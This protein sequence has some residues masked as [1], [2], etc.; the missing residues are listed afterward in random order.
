MK[1]FYV[2]C[3]KVFILSF[4]CF[5]SCKQAKEIVPSADFTPYISAYTGGVITEG[6]T[7]VVELTQEQSWSVT[8]KEVEDKLFSFSPSVKGTAHWL[9]NNTIEFVPQEGEMKPGT[10]YNATFALGKVLKTDEK[11]SK[12]DFSFRVQE[13]TLKIKTNPVEVNEDKTITVRGEL[14]FSK[15]SK[16]EDVE[17]TLTASLGDEKMNVEIEGEDNAR[18]YKFS[19]TGVERVDENREL[20]IKVDGKNV[21]VNYKETLSINIPANDKFKL[22]DYEIV[23]SPEYGLRLTFSD[24]VSESQDLNGLITLKNVASYTIKVNANQVMLFFTPTSK[25]QKLEVIIDQGLKNTDGELFGEIKELTISLESLKPQ[26]EILSS[27]MI[28]PNTDKIYLP[29]RAVSLHAIDLKI[30]RVFENNILMFLQNNALSVNS[31]QQLRRAGRLV[32]KKTLK[33]EKDDTKTGH[34]WENY[35]IDLT[36]LIK[37]QPGD[38][39]RIELSFKESYASYECEN[40]AMRKASLKG[41][42]S[43]NELSDASQANDLEDEYW[44]TPDSYYSVGYDIHRDWSTYEWKEAENPCHPTYYMNVKR[45]AMANILVSNLGMIAKKNTNNKLWVAVSNIIDTKPVSSAKVTAYNYQLQP[46]VSG[47]TD[48]DG[49]AVLSPKNKPFILVAESGKEKAYLRMIERET[50]MLSRFDIGGVE[51]KKGLKGY[52]YGE[53]GVWR[54]GDTLHLAFMLEDREGKIPSNHPISLEL[55][56]PQGQFYKKVISTDGLNGLYVFNI[57]IKADAPTGLWNAYVKVGGAT[58]HKGLRI[59][60]IKPNRLKINLDLPEVID[61]SKATALIG[62]HSKWLTGATARNLSAKMEL[63]LNKTT[64]RFKGYGKYIFNSPATKFSSST[65]QI[66]DGTLDG[67]GDANFSMKIPPAKNAPGMLNANITCRVFEPGGDA[68]IF[69]QSVPFSPYSSYVGINF[70]KEK[71]EHYK[72]TDEDHTFDVV[73]LNSEGQPISRSDIEYKIYRIGWSWWWEFKDE[74][75]ESYVN[76][77]SYKPLYSGKINTENGKGKLKFRVDYPDWGRFLVLLKDTKSGHTTGG[78]LLVDWPS[79]RGR[80]NK[81][82]PDGVK[83]LTFALDKTSYEAGEEAV[84][85]IPATATDGRALIALENGTE[86]VMR[87][88]VE[89]TAGNETKYT[90]KVTEKMSPNIYV[91]IS[92]LQPHAATNDLPIRM[93]GIMPVFVSNKSSVLEPEIKVSDVLRPEVEFDISVKEKDGKPMTY[94]LAIVDEGLLDLTNFK[95]PDPWNVFYAR[96]ALGI[97]TWDMFDNVMGAYAGKYGE[98]FAVGGDA[99]I[100]PSSAKANRFKPVVLYEGPISLSAGEEK[101]HT[102]RL[103]PYIGSVRVMLVAGHDG[104]YG[105]T[106]KNVTVRS[107]LMLLSS[108]PRVLSTNEEINLPVNVFAMEDGVKKVSVKVETTGKLKSTDRK[109]Q[110]LRFSAPGDKIVYF[111]MRTST[112]KGI[113]KVTITASA[114][115]HTSSETIEIDVRNPNPPNITIESK[116]LEKGGNVE[117]DYSINPQN[118]EDWIKVEMSRIPTVDISRRFDYLYN[119]NHYCT[120]QLTSR[121]FPLLFI[122]DFKELDE[123]EKEQSKMNITEAINDLYSRQLTNGGFSYWGGQSYVNDWVCSYAGSFL[124]VA[125]ERGYKV[126]NSVVNKWIN[127]Q[128]TA[129]RNWRQKKGANKRYSYSQSDFLQAY[130]LYSLALAGVPEMGAMNRLK[131]IKDLSLQARWRLAAAY[132]LGGKQDAAGEIVFNAPTQIAPYSSNN[133]TYGDFSRDEAMILETLVL[134]NRDEEAFK[135]ARKVSKNL[136]SE[137]SFNTQTTAYA[138]IAMGQLAS[139][140]SGAFDLKWFLNGEKQ[141]RVDTR[142]TI[143]Q[144]QLPVTPSSGKVKIQNGDKGI[145]YVSLASKTSPIVDT[146][147]AIAENIKLNVLYTDMKGTPLNVSRLGQGTDFYAIIKV[148]NISIGNYYSDVALTHIIPSGWEVYNERMVAASTPESAKTAISNAFTYQDVRDDRILTYFDLPPGVSKEI[149]VRLQASYQGDFV[150]PAIQCEAMYDASTHARTKAGRVMVGD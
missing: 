29:F 110:S 124:I 141:G 21:G 111:P 16:K 36:K 49:F 26:V 91:H 48:V 88:W 113:E 116:L 139:K 125:R 123:K 115:K 106:D 63:V 95:T 5:Y 150:L 94:T 132:A 58:F 142:R 4:C 69:S 109:K 6:E 122:S 52:I 40:E 149:K 33:L 78:T 84:V 43:L 138:M 23:D 89:L 15:I 61:A 31:S 57:P 39:Y 131:E 8:A 7:I 135:Q 20:Y 103:P 117:F 105:K 37:Q 51:L 83:M 92:L 133:P 137:S 136:S 120:E 56:N 98:L 104:A 10:M 130:R 85:T 96:E 68:S 101:K 13:H 1:P 144:Q 145:V 128:R 76:N 18:L 79:W 72:F 143:F 93:Y 75:F 146:L 126:N 28:M 81:K 47:T 108:L 42:I 70:N 73:T 62:I 14:V 77:S 9:D 64:T 2:V 41:A 30:I 66:F 99:E 140:M 87:E 34:S 54:P 11:L 82:N 22:Y 60:T 86:V 3:F 90:F 118:E 148:S 67:N 121:A 46:I 44:D 112:E 25:M 107:P 32:Y 71:N 97:Q 24:A 35:S 53:R 114:G 100:N 129:A 80:S 147:P 119:Y 45:K 127:Y 12:F 50:N 134:M 74:S 65:T 55:F 102:L 19:V 59:E 17:Q 38:I 27:G